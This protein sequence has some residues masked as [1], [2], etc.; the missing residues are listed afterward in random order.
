LPTFPGFAILGDTN[1]HRTREKNE[2]M[3]MYKSQRH[4]LKR[5]TKQNKTKKKKKKKKNRD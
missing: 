2:S 3:G 1:F 5:K 4:S